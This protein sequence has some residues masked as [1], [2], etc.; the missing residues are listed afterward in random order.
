MLAITSVSAIVRVN[1][2][3]VIRAGDPQVLVQP[4]RDAASLTTVAVLLGEFLPL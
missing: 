2:H 4:G 3:N 1:V